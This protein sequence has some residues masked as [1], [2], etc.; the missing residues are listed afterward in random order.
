M[1]FRSRYR[2]PSPVIGLTPLIDVVFILL[3]FFML[4]SSFLDWRGYEMSVSVQDKSASSPVDNPPALVRID[5]SGAITLNG[6]AVPL[7]TLA[8]RLQNQYAGAQ[9]HLQPVNGAKLQ[10]LVHVMDVLG[11]GGIHNV[12]LIEQ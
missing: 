10:L 5:G 6:D 3:V 12:D 11:R 9:V 7:D 2:S 8:G 1:Q 4:A